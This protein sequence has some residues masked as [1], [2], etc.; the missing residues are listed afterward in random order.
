MSQRRRGRGV[1]KLFARRSSLYMTPEAQSL[2]HARVWV[3]KRSVA[4][5]PQKSAWR[6]WYMW[7]FLESLLWF[8]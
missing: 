5:F 8:E 4:E 3:I 1:Q 7:K 2:I 6:V